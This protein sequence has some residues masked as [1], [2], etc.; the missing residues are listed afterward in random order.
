M[1]AQMLER[2]SVVVLDRGDVAFR[3]G[4]S[5]TDLFAVLDGKLKVARSSSDGRETLLAVLGPSDVFGETCLIEGAPRAGTVTAITP[6]TLVVLGQDDVNL[7]ITA[8]P[9]VVAMLLRTLASQVR[10]ANELRTHQAFSDV[11]A[12]VARA[13]LDLSARFGVATMSGIRVVHDLTQEEL[14]QYVGAS[15]ETVN[16]ALSD[17]ASRGWLQLEIRAVVL[18]DIPRLRT[19]AGR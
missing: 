17:F 9:D 6:A 8:R 11:A 5:A 16:K 10:R 15:R 2:A 3:Q 1:A 19:R 14:A 18:R 13:L 12:R 7:L 4:E